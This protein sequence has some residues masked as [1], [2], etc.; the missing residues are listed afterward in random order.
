[1]SHE[2]ASHEADLKLAAK[3]IKAGDEHAK[4]IRGIVAYAEL[5]FQVGWMIEWD[6]YRI[7]VEVLSTS[8]AM[9]LDHKGTKGP[10]LAELKQINLPDKIYHQTAM[11]SYQALR[12]IHIQRRHHKHPDWT[13]FCDWIQTLP[14]FTTLIRPEF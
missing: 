1:M 13:L 2:K 12:R 6:T 3:L 11:I 7:G 5:D 4:A 14:Y 9:Y 8:S 10:A